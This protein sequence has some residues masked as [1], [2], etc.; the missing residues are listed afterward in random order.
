MRRIPYSK[1]GF[2]SPVLRAIGS[3]VGA[4]FLATATLLPAQ[5][6]S[7]DTKTA[8]EKRLD[9][10]RGEIRALTPSG[11]PQLAALLQSLEATCQHPPFG[12]DI[13]RN[14]QSDG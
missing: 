14:G 2:R 4:F 6:G 10:V 3:L 8:I 5:D 13:C 9:D 7:S 12:T 1:I 11:D